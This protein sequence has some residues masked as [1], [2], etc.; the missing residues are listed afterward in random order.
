M[1][2]VRASGFDNVESYSRTFRFVAMAIKV[3]I[4][5]GIGSGKTTACKIFE[6]LGV[7]VFYADE[8]AK[9]LYTSDQEL[10]SAVIDTFGSDIYP[11]DEFSRENLAAAVFG[12]SNKL[13]ALNVLVHPALGRKFDSWARKYED[14]PFILKEAAILIE[15]GAHKACN[16]VIVV[17]CPIQTRIDRVMRRDGVAEE[18]VRLRMSHQLSDQERLAHSTFEIKNDGIEALTPQVVDIHRK[19][20]AVVQNH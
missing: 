1:N 8:E 6:V 20:T 17:S 15:S 16:E 2:D 3:G 4:T 18:S 13:E 14:R 10:K 9:S 12:D 7:P 5:G 19:I 11:E